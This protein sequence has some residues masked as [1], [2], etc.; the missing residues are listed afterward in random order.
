MKPRIS[1]GTVNFYSG[2]FTE[3][4]VKSTLRLNQDLELSFLIFDNGSDDGSLEFLTQE[5]GLPAGSISHQNPH[6][7]P[8]ANHGFCVDALVRHETSA[9]KD[10]LCLID[11]DCFSLEEGWLDKY[12]GVMSR[13]SVDVLGAQAYCPVEREECRYLWPGFLILNKKTVE[14]IRR[15]NWSFVPRHDAQAPNDSGQAVSWSLHKEKLV[16]RYLDRTPPQKI[17]SVQLEKWSIDNTVNHF[18]AASMA[19]S[20]KNPFGRVYGDRSRGRYWQKRVSE[21]RLFRQAPIRALL[22]NGEPPTAGQS[23]SEARIETF[24]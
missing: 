16:I 8:S 18:F 2:R 9:E 15:E 17:G 13:D 5:P 7:S 6:S 4:L 24:G 3:L 19:R 23:S 22:A 1:V 12:I 11:S 14:I 21:W 20:T 10:Y